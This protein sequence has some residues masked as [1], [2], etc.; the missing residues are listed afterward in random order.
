M[1]RHSIPTIC[2]MV[3][4]ETF[5]KRHRLHETWSANGVCPMTLGMVEYG[6]GD[7]PVFLA[8]DM[9]KSRNYSEETAK[10]IDGEIKKFI[11]DAYNDATRILNE[12]KDT[13]EKIALALLEYETL[14]AKH[15]QDIIDFGEMKNPPSMPKPPPVPDDMEKKSRT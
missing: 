11:D 3:H 5:A 6:E 14:D 4:Q 1:L 10:T 9:N 15:L 8:R 2:R 13:V 12:N 7:S